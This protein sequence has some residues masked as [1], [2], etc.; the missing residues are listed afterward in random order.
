MTSDD[1]SPG[2]I[3]SLFAHDCWPPVRALEIPVATTRAS[4]SDHVLDPS[5]DDHLLEI[6]DRA[7]DPEDPSELR[8]LF[9][10]RV[11]S[12]LPIGTRLRPEL[13]EV[14]GS[15]R[16]RRHVDPAEALS[17]QALILFVKQMFN[18]YFREDLYGALDRKD[19]ILL[20]QGAVDE[21]CWGL[22]AAVKASVHYALTRDWYG[23]S[24]SRGRLAAREA[25]AR[26]ET[27]RFPAASY[28]ADNVAVTMGGTFAIA[29]IADFVLANRPTTPALCAIPNYPPLVAA[30]A[31]RAPVTLV[32]TSVSG[33]RTHLRGLLAQLRPDTPMVLLQTAT[34]PTGT[35]VDEAELERLVLTASPSTLI[36]LDECHE[37]LGPPT[38]ISP[39]R[40]RANVVRVSSLSKTWSAPGLKVGWIV[41]ATPFISD[42][43]EYASTIYGG[44]PSFFYT[45]AEVLARFECWR[46]CGYD[47]AELG[48]AEEFEAQYGLDP[49]V[50]GRAYR[51]YRAE[52]D[53]RESELIRLRD[54]VASEL[55]RPGRQVLGAPYSINMAVAFEGYQDSYQLFRELFDAQSVALFPGLLTYCLGGGIGRVTTARPP[56]EIVA[57]IQRISRF[58]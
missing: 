18:Y 51:S 39:A 9:I 35:L 3:P 50:L 23:Y 44:P 52:R 4:L 58:R 1:E 20:S 49:A 5:P 48:L 2:E 55:S 54:Y 6:F 46:V 41:A 15:S 45:A 40:A 28:E 16:V 8:R 34:N 43:Y 27:A 38:T 42:F 14:W 36:V 29:C 56:Q 24:D 19:A 17:S 22:P 30:I 32:P 53:G 10:G 13:A 12:R 37:W 21:V 25:I 26:Y 7:V 33:G 31:R 57:A 47:G 11:E